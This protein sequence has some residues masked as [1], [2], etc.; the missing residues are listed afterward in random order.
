MAIGSQ[1][2]K[3]VKPNPCPDLISQSQ[4]ISIEDLSQKLP[5]FI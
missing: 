5:M 4:W 1:S 2:L 3:A